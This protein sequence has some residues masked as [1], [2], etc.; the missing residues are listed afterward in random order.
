MSTNFRGRF[1]LTPTAIVVGICA[2]AP[3][4]ADQTTSTN[5]QGGLEEIVVTARK[6]S[7][8]LQT[9]PIAVTALSQASLTQQQ[10]FDVADLQH[11]A[12]DIAIGGA[13]TGPSSIVYL[14]IRGEAQNSPNSASDNSV[15]IYVDGVYIARPI[16]GNQGFLDVNQVEVLRGPQGT[17]FGRNTTGG[18]LNITTNQPTDS[19]EGYVKGGYGNYNSKLGEAVVNLPLVSGT[20]DARLAVRFD[21]HDAYFTNPLNS[22]FD[23]GHL[24][25]DWQARGQ[26]KWT[27]NA[28]P[29][30]IVWSY[31]YAQEE[32]SGTP[33]AL[34][35]VNTASTLGGALP[36]PIGTLLGLLGVN[37][38]NYLVN[39]NSHSN[40][41]YRFSYGGSLLTPFTPDAA[42]NTPFNKNRDVGF[43]QNLDL[44]VGQAHIKSITAYRESDSGNAAD[45]D[46]MPIPYYGFVSQYIQH[47]FSEELQISGKAG[48]FDWIGGAYYFQEAGSERSDSQAFG[49]LS[50]LGGT[51]AQPIE[52]S[53]STFDARSMALFGQTNY[54]FTDTIRATVGYR[55]TWDVRDLDQ[56]GRNDIYG[57]NVCAVGVTAGTPLAAYPNTCQNPYSANFSYPAW[58]ASLD[59]EVMPN[60]FIYLKTDKAFMAGGFNTRPVPSTVDPAFQPESNMDV[61]AGLKSDMLDH[62]LRTNVAL[63]HGWQ[64]D[65]QRIVNS[66]VIEDGVPTG[67]QDVTNAGKTRTYGAELEITAL[68]WTGMQITASGAYLHAAYVAGTFFETQLLPD[69][70]AV[71]VDRSNEPVPQAPKFTASLGA[72]Q[73]VPLPIGSLSAHLD[74]AWRD[75]LVYTWDTPSPLQP[76]A[77]QALYAAQNAFGVIPSYGLLN[78]RIALN[79]DHPNVE[80][81]LWGR[82]LTNTEYYQNQ[83][84]IY[85]SL[86]LAEDFQGDPRTFGV[87][88]TYRFKQ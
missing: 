24:K 18:A 48:K 45:L 66:V 68:P 62:H 61:E 5:Q 74:Y 56:S 51:A 42:I 50:E 44:D 86:G 64:D 27:P 29:L 49:F 23:P 71:R 75:K 3:A 77:V 54:H 2:A 1:S 16:I 39:A 59:W 57:A 63:F 10:V 26:L 88:F 40:P 46:G 30:T 35:G 37:P 15:G 20:L 9:T 72:T 31:D 38:S 55:Y 43:A 69:G 47:Q 73:T 70:T 87:T 58:T 67:T 52:R 85:A 11:A 81:A 82:N 84:D 14:A 76:A 17:L 41:N 65:V 7:E 33:T 34:L 28:I 78:A 19:F 12:P 21:D 6:T 4:W 22:A 53:Y 25:E 36:L 80:V 13:G 79:L 32:D 83:L 8:P 60:T